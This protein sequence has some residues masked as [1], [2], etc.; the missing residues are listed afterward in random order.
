MSTGP[1]VLGVL[2][3]IAMGLLPTVRAVAQPLV[4]ATF[5]IPKIA[6]L[7]L[8]VMIFGIREVS[9]YAIIAVAVVYLVLISTVAGV[10]NIDKMYWMSARVSTRAGS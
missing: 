9:K 5:P 8:F 2:L 3:G 4:D 10:R 7:P 6:I 1:A